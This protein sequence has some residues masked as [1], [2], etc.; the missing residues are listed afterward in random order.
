MFTLMHPF[1]TVFPISSKIVLF[2]FFL[3]NERFPSQPQHFLQP[4]QPIPIL[5]Q[6]PC[7]HPRLLVGIAEVVKARE[8]SSQGPRDGMGRCVGLHF[9]PPQHHN[10][11]RWHSRDANTCPLIIRQH[12][13]VRGLKRCYEIHHEAGR[14]EGRGPRNANRHRRVRRLLGF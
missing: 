13:R 7:L 1:D 6:G 14:E 5:T 3:D 8:Q 12:R 2:S 4:R 9:N 11:L 10:I